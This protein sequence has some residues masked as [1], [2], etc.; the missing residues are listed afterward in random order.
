M[1]SRDALA[2]G[3]WDARRVYQQD[4]LYGIVIRQQLQE[5]IRQN[6]SMYPDLFGGN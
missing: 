5:L 2:A 4:G 3:V 1:I 6:K